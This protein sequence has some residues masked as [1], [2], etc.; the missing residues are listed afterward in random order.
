MKYKLLLLT[1]LTLPK[2][3]AEEILYNSLNIDGKPLKIIIDGSQSKIGSYD[4]FNSAYLCSPEDKYLCLE[5]GFWTFAIPK[6]LHEIRDNAWEFRGKTFKLI[7]KSKPIS[8]LGKDYEVDLITT[9]Y[10][11]DNTNKGI[12]YFYFSYDKGL[13]LLGFK[14]ETDYFGNKYLLQGKCGFG[15]PNDCG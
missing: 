6:S 14:N 2:H 4:K 12:M 1:L 11:F 3:Y 5:S 7:E 10:N 15:A 9:A 13:I 8:I